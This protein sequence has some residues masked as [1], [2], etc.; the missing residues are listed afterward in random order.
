MRLIAPI[1][2]QRRRSRPLETDRRIAGGAATA[3][4]LDQHLLDMADAPRQC[5]GERGGAGFPQT[6]RAFANDGGISSRHPRR[7]G[8][9]TRAVREHVDEGEAAFRDQL[10]GIAK[11]CLGLGREAGDQV[12]A[13]RDVRAQRL[14]AACCLDGLRPAVAALHALQD[15]IVAGLQRQVQMR[16]QPVFGGN[17]APEVLVDFTRVERGQPQ[18]AQLGD[19]GQK[20]TNHLPETWP[21]RQIGAVSGQV[22]AGQDDFIRPAGNEVARLGDDRGSRHGSARAAGVGNDTE[23]AAVVAALL[24]L[25]VGARP[26]ADTPG[27]WPR[28]PPSAELGPLPG[29]GRLSPA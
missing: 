27:R 26:K 16:H 14:G 9:R 28:H 7:R 13:E 22:H 12:G 23:G 29:S 8:T 2:P 21:V 20:R 25:K 4:G 5:G 10:Q 1:A 18:A 17:Q 3:G 24:H 15:Q 6:R 19:G 11:H